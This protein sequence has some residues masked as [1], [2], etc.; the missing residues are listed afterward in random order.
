MRLIDADALIPNNVHT[1]IR[2]TAT[3]EQTESVIYAEEIDNAPTVDAVRVV[4][5][6]D[7]EYYVETNGRIGTCELTI[8]GAED[9]GFCAWGERKNDADT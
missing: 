9:D 7:C 2:L 8:S 5:C 1:I 6:R 4:R 3:G